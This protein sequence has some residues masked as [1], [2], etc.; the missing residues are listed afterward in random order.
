MKTVI[1]HISRNSDIPGKNR[2]IG[3]HISRRSGIRGPG[4]AAVDLHAALELECRG[5]VRAGGGI[6]HALRNIDRRAADGGGQH[7]LQIGVGGCPGSAVVGWSRCVEIDIDR[8][9]Q[10]PD[11]ERFT[12]CDN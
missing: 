7:G 8:A 9:E 10:S 12:S 5:L 6:V 1:R 4:E 3:R 11:L 2:W